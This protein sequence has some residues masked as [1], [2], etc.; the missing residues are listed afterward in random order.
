[1]GEDGSVGAHEDGS[2]GVHDDGMGVDVA[3]V[4]V[5]SGGSEGGDS[6]GRENDENLEIALKKF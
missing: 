2:G 5:G 4:T 6:Q 1:M 3:V